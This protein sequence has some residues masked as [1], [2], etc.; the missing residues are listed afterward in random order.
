MTRNLVLQLQL[1]GIERLQFR[2]FGHVSRMPLERL[3]KQALT[4]I[5]NGKMVNKY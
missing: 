5:P 4:A 3:P 1:D 2:L